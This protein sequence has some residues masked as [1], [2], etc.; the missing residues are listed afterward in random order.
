[1]AVPC[2]RC[3]REYD[4]AL[5]EFGRTISC[6]CGS[7]VGIEPRVRP[8]GRWSK[9]R[10]VADA[11]LGRLARWLRL[12]GFDCTYSPEITDA[13][14]VRLA[15]AEGRVI[16]T[17]DRRLPEEWWVDDIYV[18]RAEE[19]RQQLFEVV[20]HFDLA[21]SIHALTRCSQCNRALERVARAA[22]SGRVPA[23][24]FEFHDVFSEC[25]SCGRIYWEGT[26]AARV[27]SVVA[28]LLPGDR[29]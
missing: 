9:R 26:H 16:L 25:P 27:R 19:L 15:A 4:V 2:Q 11:M 13:E 29:A 17:R 1:M 7:R 8:L 28:S 5:F 12:L 14:I 23:R 3:G 21:A 6:T 10:F 24:V 20:Q 18:V 22:V